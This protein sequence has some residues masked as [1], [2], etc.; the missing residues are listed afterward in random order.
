MKTRFPTIAL[1]LLLAGMV[2]AQEIYPPSP[3]VI[4]TLPPWAQAM[5]GSNPNVYEVDSLYNA[6]YSAHPFEKDYHTQYYRIWRLKAA[7]HTDNQGYIQPPDFARTAAWLQPTSNTRSRSTWTLVGAEKVMEENGSRSGDQ[8]NVYSIAQSLSQPGTLYCGTEPGEIYKSLN[9]GAN[10]SL[11][12][13]AI[14]PLGGIAAITIDPANANIVYAGANHVILK[15]TDGGLTWTQSF[16]LNNLGVNEIVVHPQNSQIVMAACSQGLYRSTNGGGSWTAVYT[17]ACYDIKFRPGSNTIVYVLKN[18]PAQQMCEFFRSSDGG[19]TYTIQSTGWYSSTNPARQDMGARLAVTPADPLR[20]YAYLIGDSKPNDYGYI[21]VYRSNDGGTTWTLP[22]GPAGGPYTATHPNLAYGTPTWTYHQGFYNCAIMA[23]NTNAD[24]ILIGGLNLWRSND[25]GLTFSSVAGYIGG[26]LQMHVDMQDFRATPTGYWIT[27]DGG[28]CQS[29]DFFTANNVVMM[30][31]VHG[32]EFWGLGTGW[33]E[34][35]IVGGLYHNG[36]IAWHENYNANEFLQLGGAEPASGYANPG[37]GKRVYSSDIGGA[38]L[39]AAIGQPISRFS[40]G[41][42]PNESYFAAESGRMDFDPRCWNIVYIGRDN[43][44]WKSVDGGA[45]YNLMHTFGT[46]AS[47]K[48][49]QTEIC[50]SNPQVMYACQHG[51]GGKLWKTTDGGVTWAQLTIPSAGA[52]GNRNRLLI[53][54]NPADENMLWLAYPSGANGNKVFV[55]TNGGTAWTNITDNNLN[56]QEPRWLHYIAQTN[57][58]LYCITNESVFY[59]NNTT[60]SW[61]VDN[62]G[63]P[64]YCNSLSAK[65]FYRD[66]K[67]K[68]ATYGRGVWEN[69]LQDLPATPLAQPQVDKLNYVMN[70]VSDSFHFEDHSVLNHAGASWQWSFP[71]GSPATSSQRNP[72]VMYAAAGTYTVTLTVTDS[73]GQTD[74]GTLVITVSAYQQNTL[75]SESYQGTFPPAGWWQEAEAPSAGQW[76]LS[77]AAGGFGNS[78]QSAIF[79]NYNFDAQGQFADM[80]IRVDMTQQPG[81]FM[82]FDVAYAPYGGQYMDSLEVL[83]STDCGNTFTSVYFK[84]GVQLS[85][86]PQLQANTFVPTA[87]QWRTDTINLAAWTNNADLLIAVRNRGYFGQAIYVDNINLSFTTAVVT[88]P[89][90]GKAALYPNPVMP[91]NCVVLSADPNETYTIEVFSPEG[92]MAHRGVYKGNETIQLPELAAGVYTCRITGSRT[93]QHQLLMVK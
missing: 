71:G 48:I 88:P 9:G 76:S 45:S 7:N 64:S 13:P 92:R 15:T 67:I 78:T 69:Q 6:W 84:G 90:Y 86:A 58:G 43:N 10:W 11:V 91:G 66:G 27:N 20:V 63:L 38:V 19:A 8:T 60:G 39:P 4:Q 35:V 77:T 31:G 3:A 44:L 54:Q 62:A 55:T 82:T 51:G 34:D 89:A 73:A 74:S 53:T 65:P 47:Q 49:I 28:I 36:T 52:G 70:C 41:L 42:W 1:Y 46:N 40:V 2:N 32:S 18:N 30:D 17:T 59:R 50:W 21:G 5:Y 26:P 29:S 56:N 12:T 14:G 72:A 79:D 61:Q 81:D 85:T 37:E 80:R 16:S 25:G 22:N 57:G 33:N 93:M 24:Q 23:S 75:L 68:L 87:S 83:V